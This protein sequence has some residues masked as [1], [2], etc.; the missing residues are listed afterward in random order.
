VGDG[1]ACGTGHLKNQVIAVFRSQN[2]VKKQISSPFFWDENLA[3]WAGVSAA[4][5]AGVSAAINKNRAR[6]HSPRLI[7]VQRGSWMFL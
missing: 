1:D 4:Q 6:Q 7:V 2:S 3:W 5:R